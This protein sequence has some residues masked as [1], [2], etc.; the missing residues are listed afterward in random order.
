M[1]LVICGFE[2]F[3]D[4]RWFDDLSMCEEMDEKEFI[5]KR[6]LYFSKYAEIYVAT[7][8][9]T[10]RTV[11]LKDL[12]YISDGKVDEKM[13]V[14]VKREINIHSALSHP[15]IV[16]FYGMIHEDDRYTLVLEY[17]K[18]GDLGHKYN[19]DGLLST[20]LIKEVVKGI[21]RA[22][23]YC[24]KKGIIHGD[25]KPENIFLD[26]ENCVKLGD[27]GGAVLLSSKEQ[28]K[29]IYAHGTAEFL[30]PEVLVVEKKFEL[31]EKADIWSFGVTLIE[32]MSGENPFSSDEGKDEIYRK[33][34]EDDIIFED[35]DCIDELGMDLIEKM[36]E[37]DPQQRIGLS[38][39]LT[40][41]F[42]LHSEK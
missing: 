9:A 7:E 10:R 39:I 27:F 32:I 41:P 8:I 14:L 36:L 37:K 31:T 15:N 35:F 26:S 21:G 29:D 20:E 4:N 16:H 2:I 42:L 22:L 3:Q 25:I 23:E 30:P 38:E 6:G 24:H 17:C 12:F 1:E 19:R 28:K 13:L 33:I 34:V 40:H 11:V 5:I 18:H